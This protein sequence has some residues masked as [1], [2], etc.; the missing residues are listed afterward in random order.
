MVIDHQLSVIY[1]G[2]FYVFWACV[3]ITYLT[4]IK[5]TSIF[6]KLESIGNGSARFL[7]FIDGLVG[8]CQSLYL[9]FV[10]VS[11]FLLLYNN[12][13]G[14]IY[15]SIAFINLIL[16]YLLATLKFNINYGMPLL[17]FGGI[18][19]SN[20]IE[21]PYNPV[22]FSLLTLRFDAL[23]AFSF[24]LG[25]MLMQSPFMLERSKDENIDLIIS[26]T[27][28]ACLTNYSAYLIYAYINYIYPNKYDLFNLFIEVVG[29][30]QIIVNKYVLRDDEK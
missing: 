7:Y 3:Q 24:R 2:L 18:L 6:K 9:S 29:L 21:V 19:L 17:Y 12:D 5:R 23:M 13:V 20:F 14:Y 8:L 30:S 16:M 4:Y 10:L 1:T 11:V 26:H 15:S 27:I 22:S 25:H 28:L